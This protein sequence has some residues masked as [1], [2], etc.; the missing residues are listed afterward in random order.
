[1][2]MPRSKIDQFEIY[3]RTQLGLSEGTI[4]V[5]KKDVSEFFDFINSRDGKA[6]LIE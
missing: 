4:G 6:G 2:A 1:M 3:T 5:Y